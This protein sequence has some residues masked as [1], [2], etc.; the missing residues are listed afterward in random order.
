MLL[1]IDIGNTNIVFGLFEEGQL[2]TGWRLSTRPDR[3]SDEYGMDC[4]LQLQRVGRQSADVSQIV[5]ASV[6]P[7]LEYS[8]SRMCQDY[9]HC[10]PLFVDAVNQGILKVDYHPP[11]DVGADRV[12]NAV[13]AFARW[14]GPLVIL[15]FGTATT[16]DAVSAEG[17]YL[18]GAIVPGV[19]LS[20]E[21]L[22]QKT[23]RLPRVA[24]V[25]PGA[26]IGR[27]TVESIQ[28]GLYY[29]SLDMIKGLVERFRC[30]L[31]SGT[32]VVATGGL[33][34]VFRPDMPWVDHF[35]AD[36]TLDGLLRIAAARKGGRS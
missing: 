11:T 28:S 33:S 5:A 27:S 29:G 20:A 31:G 25:R 32:Q 26:A 35:D 2:V 14:G 4:V 6:V 7:P 22:F 21:A 17:V 23:S 34:E 30:E 36:L 24:V 15:D 18:G 12:V 8:F 19:N 3:T 9:F 16:F 10:E 13:A 1:A